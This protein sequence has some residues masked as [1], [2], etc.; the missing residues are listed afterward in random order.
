MIYLFIPFTN[1]QNNQELLS[2]GTRW[3]TSFNK[4]PRGKEPPKLLFH[5]TGLNKPLNIINQNDTLYILAHG[6]F[7]MPGYV[8]NVRNGNCLA[9][10]HTALATIL[11]VSGLPLNHKRVK[12][13]ICNASGQMRKFASDFKRT[14]QNMG[15][16]LIDVYFYDSSVGVPAEFSDGQYHKDGVHFDGGGNVE[17]TPRFRASEVRHRVL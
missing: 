15:Y 13:Y 11:K 4:D 6:H 10:D 3:V 17:L 5:N 1:T 8:A 2:M 7:N 12:L 9:M 16:N 14:M